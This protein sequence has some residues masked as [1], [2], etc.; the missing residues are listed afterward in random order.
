MA[1]SLVPLNR[2]AGTAQPS[3]EVVISRG[4]GA[5]PIEAVAINRG[6]GNGG[7]SRNGNGFRGGATSRQQIGDLISRINTLAANEGYDLVEIVQEKIP[8]GTCAPTSTDG[9]MECSGGDRPRVPY[10]FIPWQPV[11]GAC[12]QDIPR[13]LCWM[14]KG[15][16]SFN[17]L[18]RPGSVRLNTNTIVLP[19]PVNGFAIGP[20]GAATALGVFFPRQWVAECMFHGIYQLKVA[21]NISVIAGLLTPE[22]IARALFDDLDFRIIQVGTEDNLHVAASIGDASDAERSQLAPS[23]SGFYFALAEE[24]VPFVFAP[25]VFAFDFR[26]TGPGIA[27]TDEYQVTGSIRTK[28]K[29]VC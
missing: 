8:M 29:L 25:E 23:L 4:N 28:W 3:T 7:N 9:C 16:C 19:D 17:M 15:L 1:Y 12:P 20:E 10:Q 21:W 22:Q 2:A 13:I 5:E 14:Y 26:G 27:G 11:L 24:F 6:N 18:G